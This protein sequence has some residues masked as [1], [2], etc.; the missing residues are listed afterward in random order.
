MT[1]SSGMPGLYLVTSI[2]LFVTYW[3]DKV[4]LLRYFRLTKGYTK[5]LNMTAAKLLPYAG[6]IHFFYGFIIFSY[7]NIL[8]SEINHSVFGESNDITLS[9]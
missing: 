6:I 9:S 3:I 5:N 1:Y 7:P 2:S 4:L 8:S